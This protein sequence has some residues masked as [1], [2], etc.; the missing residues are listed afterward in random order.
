MSPTFSRF[1]DRTDAGEHLASLIE[2]R[3]I[4][5]DTVLAVANGGLPVARVVVDTLDA[6]LD[7]IVARELDAPTN[8]ELAIGAVTDDGAL[9]LDDVVI[10]QL[11]V[12]SDQI[13]RT[14]E[15]EA[16][17]ARE[18][19]ERYQDND[20]DNDN[21]K[22][23]DE[24]EE[25]SNAFAGGTVLVIDDGIATRATTMACIRQVR[26]AGADRVV[27]A[28]PVAPPSVVESLLDEADDVIAVMTPSNF[29]TVG[30]FYESF[31]QVPAEA[32]MACFD[33]DR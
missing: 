16:E 5:A 33:G 29:G 13:E 30:R 7:V 8:P 17:I 12:D 6:S 20:K 1:A 9:W 32:A 27:V 3:G 19:R 14:A 11:G 4:T 21:D 2:R 15:R 22:D 25:D 24:D 23:E 28:V 26:G 31:D 18:K 10:E